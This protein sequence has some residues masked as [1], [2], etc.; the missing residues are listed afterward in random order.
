MR[1]GYVTA[2]FPYGAGEAFLMPEIAALARLGADVVVLPLFPRGP[3]REDW[4]P[5][6]GSVTVKETGLVSRPVVARAL[7]R[8]LRQPFATTRQAVRL[9]GGGPRHAAKNWA[10]VPKALWLAN[11]IEQ[12]GCEHVHV[13]WGG[14]TASAAMVAGE[15]T[16][17][18]WSLTCHRWDIYEDNLLAEKVAAARFT[19]FISERGRE[20]AVRLGA[21]RSRTCVI[22]LGTDVPE[23]ANSPEWPGTGPFALLC[24]ANLVPVK[25]HEHLLAACAAARAAGVDVRLALA[26]DGPL[27]EVLEAE[28]RRRG[29]GGAVT[30]LGHLPRS[31]I[32]DLY[33]RRAVHATVLASVEDAGGEH[34]GVPASLMEAMAHGVPVLATAT[35]S[36][37]ELLPPDLGLTVRD[38]DP[39]ALAQ[40]IVALAMDRVRYEAAA[41]SCRERIALG[42][43]VDRSASLLLERIRATVR[44]RACPCP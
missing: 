9:A 14:T 41:H 11:T 20:D 23:S 44:T 37:P 12:L 22:S 1:L 28:A 24:A 26:G 40:L 36:I 32:L 38:R 10:V 5:A 25:G 39:D 29:L 15:L 31:R 3:R 7:G 18:P 13:H 30:F 4:A 17:L 19:R 6:G 27:R 43:S 8:T 42:W 33:E 2:S 34:E 16:G 35:G 21:D